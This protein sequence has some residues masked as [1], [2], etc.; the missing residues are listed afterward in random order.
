MPFIIRRC[1]A[2][3]LM[4]LYCWG[5]SYFDYKI[6][7]T[8][9]FDQLFHQRHQ[10]NWICVQWGQSYLM[11]R[12]CLFIL[13]WPNFSWWYHNK[14]TLCGRCFI[15]STSLAPHLFLLDWLKPNL[16]LL[17]DQLRLRKRDERWWLLI[18]VDA[19]PFLAFSD[20]TCHLEDTG[21]VV[22]W[23]H[24]ATWY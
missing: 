22:F 7:T 3:H 6:Q 13:G 23:L 21:I 18:I 10:K 14:N 19:Y 20:L 8:A 5:L 1:W 12:R 15:T 16:I 24:C 4:N 17:I 9:V 11:G 2:F